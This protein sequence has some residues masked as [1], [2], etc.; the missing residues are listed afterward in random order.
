MFVDFWYNNTLNDVKK[1][2]VF[3]SDLD[4]VYRGNMYDKTGKCIGDYY[5]KNSV[6]IEKKFTCF[7]WK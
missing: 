3:F 5:T 7:D 2:T 1:I 6:E 4:A